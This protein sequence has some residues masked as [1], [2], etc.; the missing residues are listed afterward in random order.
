[1]A[2]LDELI[3]NPRHIFIKGDISNRELIEYIF[4]EFDIKGVIH[5]AAE[6]HVDNSISEPDVFIRTNVMGTFVLVDVARNYWMKAH[7]VYRDGYENSRF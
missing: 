1:M 6:S 2:N 7:Q 4:E 5:F 3:F